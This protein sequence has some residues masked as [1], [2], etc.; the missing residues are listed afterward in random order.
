MHIS[1][2]GMMGSGKSAVGRGLARS[3]GRRLADTDWLIEQRIRYSIQEFFA[4]NG[5]EAFRIVE[6][7]VLGEV[8]TGVEPLVV[9]TGGG[10]VLLPENRDRLKN[11][12]TVVWLRANANTLASRVMARAE[13]TGPVPIFRLASED[14]TGQ[15]PTL[16]GANAPRPLV[17]DALMSPN[18]H[19]ALVEKLD[20]LIEKRSPLYEA[21]AD[22]IVDVDGG[23]R[24][25]VVRSVVTRLGIPNRLDVGSQKASNKA[26]SSPGTTTGAPGARTLSVPAIKKAATGPVRGASDHASARDGKPR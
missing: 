17:A 8:L 1:L 16:T 20:A 14:A 3:L 11:Q 13:R 24:D 9:S 2:V 23:H 22:L 10:I 19:Q 5:E 25:E 12:S 18:P 4:R 26:E 21:V 6:T 15:V 7:Q